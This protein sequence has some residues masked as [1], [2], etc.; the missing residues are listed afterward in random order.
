[1]LVVKMNRK[2]DTTIEMGKRIQEIAELWRALRTMLR[3]GAASPE[4][5]LCDRRAALCRGSCDLSLDAMTV[6][7]GS[8][9]EDV[10]G[11]ETLRASSL[12]QRHSLKTCDCPAARNA[13]C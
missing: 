11:V 9:D 4:A 8:D 10:T 1:M 3:S 5:S 2:P 13:C 6:C 7:K 12:T